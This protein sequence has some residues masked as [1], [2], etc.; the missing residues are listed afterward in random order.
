MGKGYDNET[1]AIF[2]GPGNQQRLDHYLSL[3]LQQDGLDEWL[4]KVDETVII[5]ENDFDMHTLNYDA[6][7]QGEEDKRKTI[8]LSIVSTKI[9]KPKLEFF[10]PTKW[11]KVSRTDKLGYFS[12]CF[13]QKSFFFPFNGKLK[14]TGEGVFN[15]VPF[16]NNGTSLA[17]YLL[18]SQTV[19]RFAFTS[20]KMSVVP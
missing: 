17:Y 7:M 14:D 18:F 10:T 16:R 8:T 11:L 3:K 9:K 13:L 2:F 19:T 6:S 1:I 12:A 15:V 20:W 4:L 5:L